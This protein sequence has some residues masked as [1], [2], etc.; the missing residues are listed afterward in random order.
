MNS[1]LLTVLLVLGLSACYSIPDLE[2]FDRDSWNEN[3]CDKPRSAQQDLIIMQKEKLYKEGQ[4]EIKTLFGQ[5]D[6]H[7]LYNRN[8]KFFYYNLSS[9][10]CNQE[11]KKLRLSI[12]FDALDRVK[13]VLIIE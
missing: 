13:E 6:E 9:P 12:K 10:E 1:K 7:E 4:A 8:Q 3:A 2:G 11:G 5:P